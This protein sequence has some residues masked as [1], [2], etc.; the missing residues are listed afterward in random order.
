MSILS[1]RLE[2]SHVEVGNGNLWSPIKVE[3]NILNFVMP[4]SIV[5]IGTKVRHRAS[6]RG[7]IAKRNVNTMKMTTKVL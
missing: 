3:A 4:V 1:T 5:K 2:D 6:F 7:R